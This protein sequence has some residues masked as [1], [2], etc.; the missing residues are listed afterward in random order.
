MS[1]QNVCELRGD[2]IVISEWWSNGKMIYRRSC[3]PVDHPESTYSC[4]KRLG[5]VPE[6]YGV[7]ANKK[8]DMSMVIKDANN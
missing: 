2:S 1:E 7:F 5:R 6:E 8:A 3:L 4:I